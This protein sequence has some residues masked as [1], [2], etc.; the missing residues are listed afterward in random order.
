M[1]LTGPRD[2]AAYFE[3]IARFIGGTLGRGARSALKVIIDDPAGG[4]AAHGAAA[5]TAVR[6]FRRQHS[7]SYSFNWLLHDPAGVAAAVRGHARIDARAA[8]CSARSRCTSCAANLRRAFSGIVTGNVK[9]YG[10]SA[11]ER[12]GPYELAGDPAIM[13][14]SMSC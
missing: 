9:E 12:A 8:R 3:Q 14:R 7:D 6:E 1:V 10:I 4:G 11:I 5:S 2:S 13:Q